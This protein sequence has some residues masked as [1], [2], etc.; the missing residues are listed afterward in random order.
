MFAHMNIG[1]RLVALVAGLLVISVI[2]GLIGIRG[3]YNTNQGLRTVYE[4]NTVAL[5]HLAEVLDGIYQERNNVTLGMNADSSSAAEAPFKEAEISVQ[6]V[7]KAWDAYAALL[8]A[9]DKTRAREFTNAWSTYLGL[10]KKTVD[11]AKSGDYEAASENMKGDAARAFV[12]TRQALLKSMAHEQ[13]QAKESYEASAKSNTVTTLLV[14]GIL[15]LGLLLS[16]VSAWFIIRSI[17]RPLGQIRDVIGEVEQTSDFTKRV[18]LASTDEVGKTAAS[19]NALMQ[20][21]QGTLRVILDSVAEISNAS[22]ALTTSSSQVAASSIRQSE[23]AASMA[24]TVEEVT[25]S[26]NH[27]SD[28]AREAMELSRKS[29]EYSSQGGAI[30]HDAAATMMK[31][32]ETVRETSG[33]IDNLGQQSNRISSVVQVIK[34]VAEQTN[35][36]A[37]NAAIEAARA[38]EQGRGF[39][40]VAD[41][42]RKLA[43]RT[44]KATEEITQMIGAIQGSADSAVDTMSNAVSSV[45]NGVSL[46]RQAGE[47]INQIKDGAAHV[48]DVVTGISSALTEQTSASNDIAAHV[49]TMA[50]MSEENSAAADRSASAASKLENLASTMRAAVSQFRI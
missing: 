1:S 50:Q 7:K 19:F 5:I 2:T 24:A 38:G 49:E 34:D 47:A 3:L 32:A 33:T 44:T 15:G 46:A 43:E 40:V 45:D 8:D 48:I 20:T 30:I 27:V 14:L 23:A 21:L 13:E 9:E 26:I 25:V 28:S 35:L 18:P 17:T 12:D 29:G 22:H 10:S 6:H 37:L 39:A 11:L 16:V 31:M 4:N 42:V 41:E 36:L